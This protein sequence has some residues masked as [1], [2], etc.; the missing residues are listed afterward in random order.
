MT[1]G[2]SWL[3][4]HCAL[5]LGDNVKEDDVCLLYSDDPIKMQSDHLALGF[6]AGFLPGNFL[7]MQSKPNMSLVQ[8][9]SMRDN[10]ALTMS[11]SFG[12]IYIGG[13]NSLQLA[14]EHSESVELI[15]D[16]MQ[17]DQ[18]MVKKIVAESVTVIKRSVTAL[19]FLCGRSHFTSF[20]GMYECLI[21]ADRSIEVVTDGLLSLFR[22]YG[23]SSCV[24][25]QVQM[26]VAQVESLLKANSS[27][28]SCRDNTIIF[29][30]ACVY[31]EC[32]LGVA[33][34]SLLLTK[35]TD[36]VGLGLG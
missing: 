13:S 22:F 8:F 30:G 18:S 34:L 33:I 26:V 11:V 14:A 2:R 32:E 27:F 9:L 24:D 35:Y 15:S 10:K 1:D 4:L 19:G 6:N 17:I 29:H 28:K 25:G 16:L 23:R 3:P 36:V 12:G 7:C 5:A 20:T 21:N 31:L